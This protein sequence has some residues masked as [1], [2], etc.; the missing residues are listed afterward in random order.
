MKRYGN[1]W[2]KIVDLENIKISIKKAAK[3]KRKT[4]IVKHC[5]Q[6]LE[7]TAK[8]IQKMLLNGYH[9]SKYNAFNLYEP[10]LRIIYSLPFYPDRIV[11]HAI[12]NVLEPMWDKLMYVDSYASRKG[13][14]QHKGSTKTMQL[15]RKYT[16]FLKCDISQFYITIDHLILKEILTHKIKD[17]KTLCLLN[18]IINSI[19]TRDEN[20]KILNN[21][22]KHKDVTNG[23]TKLQSN[24]KYFNNRNVG[25]PIGN[26][27]SQWFGNLYLNELDTFIKHTLKI[28]GYIRYCDDFILF[29][30]DK[31]QLHSAKIKIKLFL[32][33]NLHLILSKT[34]IAQTNQGV[35]FLGYRHFPQGYVLIRKATA[36]RIKKRLKNLYALV[37]SKKISKER[38]L[39]KIS[40][41]NGWMKW[42]NSHNFNVSINFEDLRSKIESA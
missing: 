36:K 12:M 4:Q 15:T 18:E 28:K 20:I 16:Y 40:A 39:G 30:N 10:K 31:K 17:V 11:H 6:N 25:L 8:K 2:N 23:I 14:G 35:D 38:A 27:L 9:T 1:L 32:F 24:L 13:K 19:N 26:Y 7:E 29:S 33:Y 34:D 3:R 21:L 42:A 41:A 22:P 37:I 5:L